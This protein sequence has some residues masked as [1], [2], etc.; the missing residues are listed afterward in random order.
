M[1]VITVSGGAAFRQ[2]SPSPR[3]R[4]E[5]RTDRRTD[6]SDR[7]PTETTPL[8]HP[9]NCGGSQARRGALGEGRIWGYVQTTEVSSGA[10]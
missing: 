2:T 5:R 7:D 9:G 6:E 10:A 1:A 4:S 3:D 8:K